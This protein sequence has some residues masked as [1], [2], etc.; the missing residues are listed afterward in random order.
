MNRP[1]LRIDRDV[2]LA[3]PTKKDHDFIL[4]PRGRAIDELDPPDFPFQA[5]SV[6]AY[7]QEGIAHT[8]P[9]LGLAKNARNWD[10]SSSLD[11]KRVLHGE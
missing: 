7:K 2:I 3:Q 8:E 9:L 1:D 5:R 11:G 10:K 6:R 4:R